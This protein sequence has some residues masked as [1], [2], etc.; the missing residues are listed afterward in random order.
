MDQGTTEASELLVG[1][2]LLA[3]TAFAVFAV[4][5]ALFARVSDRACDIEHE[6]DE[7]RRD[8]AWLEERLSELR[9]RDDG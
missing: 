9:E 5:R 4:L 6:A 3:V 1:L 2:G 8:I 7:V